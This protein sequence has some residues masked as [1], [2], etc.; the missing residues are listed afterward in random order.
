MQRYRIF[1][2]C[3]PHFVTASIVKWLPVFV[4]SAPCEIIAES[5]RFCRCRKGLRIHAYVIMP[6]HLHM[7]VSAECDLSDVLRD[8]KRHTSKKLVEHFARIANPPFINVFRY[9]GEK[10]HPSTDHKVWQDGNHP[11]MIMTQGFF[12]EKMNY[13]HENPLRKGLV[14]DPVAWK[15]SSIR[16]YIDGDDTPLEVDGLEW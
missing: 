14:T 7:I 16:A 15:W 3:Y 6:T 12:E 10:Q 2:Q 4:S 13:I 8:L 1:E 5:L 11:E 9:C